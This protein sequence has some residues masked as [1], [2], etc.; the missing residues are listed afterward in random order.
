MML[1]H[2]GIEQRS[3]TCRLKTMLSANH[4]QATYL[5]D[6]HLDMVVFIFG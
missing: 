5:F 3:C 4:I 2:A 1:T 6:L